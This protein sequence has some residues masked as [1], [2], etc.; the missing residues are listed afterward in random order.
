M[1]H[2]GK[3]AVE[4]IYSPGGSKRLASIDWHT[5]NQINYGPNVGSHQQL[6]KQDFSNIIAGRPTGIVASVKNHS[7]I[8][9]RGSV[10]ESNTLSSGKRR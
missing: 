5:Q 4:L 1:S 2:Q 10:D 6:P 8:M 7:E 3:G 9:K